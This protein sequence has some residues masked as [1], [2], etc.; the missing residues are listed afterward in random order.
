M[1]GRL[2]DFCQMIRSEYG[3]PAGIT[4]GDLAK[5]FVSHSG[6]SN[7]PSFIELHS[8]LRQYGVGEITAADLS[9]GKLKGHHFSYKG[10][11][12]TVQYEKGL[13][14]GSIEHV[15]MHELY[16]IIAEQSER[17]CASYR[18]LPI[19]Q[20]C[21]QANRFAAAALMQAEVFLRALFESG[22]D[23]V[24]LHHRFWKAY[25]SVAIRA[26][27]VLNERNKELPN[28]EKIDLMV[29][30]Y[31]RMEEGEPNAW[32]L[33]TPDKFQIRYSPRTKGIRLGTK[34][35]VWLAGGRLRGPNYRAPRYPWHLIPKYGDEVTPNSLAFEV[36]NTGRCHCLKKATGFDLWGFNDLTFVAQPV[37]WFG[38]LAKV[39]L[40]GVRF[41]D[42]QLLDAQL[43]GLCPVMIDESYQLI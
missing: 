19:P 40:V 2:D 14:M 8:V 15:M 18:A 12:Y 34:G 25:S 35:G 22:F 37:R 41:K 1:A 17:W 38:K 32:G 43:N 36:I 13:W 11:E 33:C 31:E 9:T 5:V 4:P 16:E 10:R 29:M 39:I 24:E 26:V 30:I 27:E 7:A 6:L 21:A 20:I 3:S 28:D 42:R 23:T